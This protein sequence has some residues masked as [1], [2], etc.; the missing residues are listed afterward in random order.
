M[1]K[2]EMDNFDVKIFSNFPIFYFTFEKK[3]V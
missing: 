1:S 2:E 3:W